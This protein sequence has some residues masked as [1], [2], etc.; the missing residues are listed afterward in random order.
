MGS[1]AVRLQADL[2]ERRDLEQRVDAERTR[3]AGEEQALAAKSRAVEKEEATNAAE[4]GA[5]AKMTAD[6]LQLEATFKNLKEA[7]ER[8]KQ[9]YSVVPYRG[10]YGESR[11]PL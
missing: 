8:E 9:T 7:R 6:L 3:L 10:K 1:G 5:K 2:E 11:R 4:R